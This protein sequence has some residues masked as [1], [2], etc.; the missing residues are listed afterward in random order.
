[1]NLLIGI[2]LLFSII[3]FLGFFAEL[4]FKKSHIP[5]VLFLIL[6]GVLLSS[7]FNII[8]PNDF[9]IE[10]TIFVNFALIYL[11]FQGSLN[12]DFKTLFASLRGSTA[13]SIFSFIITAGVIAV[14]S[15]F[16]FNISVLLAILLGVTLGGTSSAVV[17]P[18]VSQLP[19]TKNTRSVLT[20]ESAISDV[21]SIVGAVTIIGIIQT[22]AVSSTGIISSFIG[23]ISIALAL[24]AIAGLI[25]TVM[26]AKSKEL[27]SSEMVT[28]AAVVLLFAVIESE[29]I[30]AS[31]AIAVLAF[32]LILGNAKSI[33]DLMFPKAKKKE[34]EKIQLR[35]VISTSSKNFYSEISFFVKVF[36]FVY[37][38]IL[39]NFSQPMVFIWGFILTLAVYISRPISVWLA[40]G[41]QKLD[42][43]NKTSLEILIPKGLAAAVI[44]QLA[45]SEGVPGA[46]ELVAPVFSVVLISILMT[47]VLVFLNNNNKFNG[48]GALF[49][50]SKTKG[51]TKLK[52]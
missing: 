8:G 48:F 39:M 35:N 2:F 10:A 1:M 36:F 6:A 28:V 15:Y 9:G 27:A 44:I 30:G 50:G 24:G 7:V 49:F 3:I 17:I 18:L 41:R 21:L 26:L 31:G 20:I 40:M 43:V 19:I 38:G 11:L 4:L 42:S 25:W 12:L 47:G 23:S 34:E 5:D 37:L 45:V 13:L 22:G 14:L 29:F 51:Q 32:G 52:K 16:I 46:P 33:L